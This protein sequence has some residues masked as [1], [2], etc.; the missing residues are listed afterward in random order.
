MSNLNSSLLIA[1]AMVAMTALTSL[2]ARRMR[3]PQ[4]IL[5][6]LVGAALVFA[7]GLP[8]VRLNPDLFLLVLL[9]PLLYT[10]GVGMLS[11][12]HI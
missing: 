2:V 10:S 11:L 8:R 5:L 3:V 12:I 6:V 4:P 9:P 7:P 1:F